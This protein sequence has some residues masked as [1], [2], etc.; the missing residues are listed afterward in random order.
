MGAALSS[1]R[2]VDRTPPPLALARNTASAALA[3][4]AGEAELPSGPDDDADGDPGWGEGGDPF[5]GEGAE[6]ASPGGAAAWTWFPT[7]GSGARA[8]KSGNGEGNAGE[9]GP[10]RV[11]G[12]I[13]DG[14]ALCG[15]GGNDGATCRGP[16]TGNGTGRHAHGNGHI[17]SQGGPPPAGEGGERLAVPPARRPRVRCGVLRWG[18]PGATRALLRAVGA[19]AADGRRHPHF[20]SGAEGEPEGGADAPTVTATQGAPPAA[21]FVGYHVDAV[22]MADVAY[23]PHGGTSDNTPA[24]RALLAT[25]QMLVGPRTLVLYAHTWRGREKAFFDLL[26]SGGFAVAPVP[27]ARLHPRFQGAGCPTKLFTVYLKGPPG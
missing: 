12:G 9:G 4:A 19:A 17:S 18:E 22:L 27:Q 3:A 1:E 20:R 5:F 11:P 14:P 8:E 15:N 25:L 23:N 13:S 2:G 10:E 6:G 7:P 21:C 24:W 16:S 26:A